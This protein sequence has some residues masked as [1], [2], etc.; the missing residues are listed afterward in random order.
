MY[1]KNSKY[2]IILGILIV[3]I[4][5]LFVSSLIYEHRYFF[6]DKT[7]REAT[8]KCRHTPIIGMG[9]VYYRPGS[10]DHV[11]LSIYN[12]NNNDPNGLIRYHYETFCTI[13]EAERA[14]YHIHDCCGALSPYNKHMTS[15]TRWDS[16]AK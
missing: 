3:I 9:G 15:T 2:F 14:G 6:V 8:I 10:E 13:D 12:P 7:L 1:K 16:N 4:I 11:L 5:I